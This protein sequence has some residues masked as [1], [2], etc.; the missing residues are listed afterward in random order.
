MSAKRLWLLD[1]KPEFEAMRDA[2]EALNQ[3]T[4]L[5]QRQFL[6]IEEIDDF[7]DERLS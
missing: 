6:F 3:L 7:A 4:P 5:G 1:S 2:I